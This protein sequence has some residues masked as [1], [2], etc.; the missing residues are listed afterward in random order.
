MSD[1]SPAYGTEDLTGAHLTEADL[2]VLHA[3]YEHLLLLDPRYDDKRV[4]QIGA[5]AMVD[6]EFRRQLVGDTGTATG[7]DEPESPGRI[8]VRFLTNTPRTLIVVLPP[9]AGATE[10]F[11][12]RIRD[13]LRSRTS[14]DD[15]IFKDDWLDNDK[16]IKDHR[17]DG[18]D[19]W[20]SRPITALALEE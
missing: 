18:T 12:A 3:W 11:P 2:N 8:D 20:D 15:S 9:K 16:D 5:R 17:V 19:T 14:H 10:Y 1:E 6:D 4:R 13:A 7:A